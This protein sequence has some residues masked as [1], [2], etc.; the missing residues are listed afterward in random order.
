VGL[1]V[2]GLWLIITPHRLLSILGDGFGFNYSTESRRLLKTLLP[3]AAG[4]ALIVYGVS[5]GAGTL[6][7]GQ[8][9]NNYQP[10]AT[11]NSTCNSHSGQGICTKN[12][13]AS[14]T[15]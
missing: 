1:L 5:V 7:L 6:H 11:K 10:G 9:I 2:I 8:A 15:P 13:P 14:H 4:A 3:R 12:Q